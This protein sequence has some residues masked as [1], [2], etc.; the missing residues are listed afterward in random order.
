M[1]QSQPDPGLA[2][3]FQK[4]KMRQI[5]AAVPAVLVIILL[6]VTGET[7]SVAGIPGFILA[8]VGIAILLA[9]TGFSLFN[10]RCPSCNKYL[11]KKINPHFCARCG[12]QL[13]D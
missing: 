13:Q 4:R 6:V 2:V 5:V 12:V 7:G 11:G 3:E 1:V 9:V 8:P 10:W